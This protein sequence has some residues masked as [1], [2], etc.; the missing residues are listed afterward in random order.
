[1]REPNFLIIGAA[2]SATTS[3]AS[4]L[5]NHPEASISRPKEP[6]FFSMDDRYQAGWLQYLSLFSH[7]GNEIAIGDASTSYSRIRYYPKVFER[8]DSYLKDPKIIYMVRHPIRRIE[9]AYVEQMTLARHSPIKSISEA[10]ERVPMMV[11]SS[12]Y[13]EVYSAY[14]DHYSES[15]IK[16]V[17][18]EDYVSEQSKVFSEVCQFLGI[19][20]EVLPAQDKEVSNT[21]E[22]AIARV[23]DPAVIDTRWNP[24]TLGNVKNV[25]A[26]DTSR[27]LTHFDRPLEY[28]D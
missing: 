10:V 17:W 3:L 19:D 24:K 21:R 25:L 27:F 11:D 8:L 1:M 20:S 23:G 6:H 12:R 5:D 9:S 26:D 2:K 7:C 28:W 15:Q 16:V 14:R 18:F 13:W 22:D 4:L